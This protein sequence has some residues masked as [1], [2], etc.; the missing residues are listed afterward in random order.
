[1]NVQVQ[2]T[3]EVGHV[4]VIMGYIVNIDSSQGTSHHKDRVLNENPTEDQNKTGNGARNSEIL[5]GDDR[6]RHCAFFLN[7]HWG[8]FTSRYTLL[9]DSKYS[10]YEHNPDILDSHP[11]TLTAISSI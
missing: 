9:L 11:L 3:N 5:T 6:F 8:R 4:G 10:E 1:M 2:K 7:L